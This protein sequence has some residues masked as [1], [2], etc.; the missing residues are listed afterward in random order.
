MAMSV[1]PSSYSGSLHIFHVIFSGFYGFELFDIDHMAH[2]DPVEYQITSPWLSKRQQQKAVS[3]PAVVGL[4][5]CPSSARLPTQEI[6]SSEYTPKK[7][8]K[9]PSFAGIFTEL[10]RIFE[11]RVYSCLACRGMQPVLRF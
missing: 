1:R 7:K 2:S 9:E 5:R 10:R 3:R 4:T 11:P 6:K 8:S